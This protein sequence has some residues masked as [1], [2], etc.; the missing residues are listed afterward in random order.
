[1]CAHSLFC[2]HS[3]HADLSCPLDMLDADRL[4][5]I[6]P[7]FTIFSDP[8]GMCGLSGGKLLLCAR[9]MYTLP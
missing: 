6:S 9:E 7:G 1:M 8:H 5:T 4:F 3:L 2:I